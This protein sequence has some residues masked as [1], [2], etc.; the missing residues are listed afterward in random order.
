[1]CQS[2]SAS[3]GAREVVALAEVAADLAQHVELRAGLDALGDDLEADGL[4]EAD[5][6]AH[7]RRVV[8]GEREALDE[9]ARDLQ[10]VERQVAQVAER[11]VAGAEVVERELHAEVAELLQRLGAAHGV[12]DEQRLGHLEHS[13]P[14]A[15]PVRW[16]TPAIVSSRSGCSSSIADRF[17]WTWSVGV[18]L[19]DARARLLEH[20]A[21]ERHDQARAPPRAG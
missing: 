17:T 2:A 18:A 9:L 21:A 10:R 11:R 7:E 1:M 5:D 16:I 4:G 8:V 15:M 13:R 6:Q 19:A 12:L 3:I 14:G 20:V